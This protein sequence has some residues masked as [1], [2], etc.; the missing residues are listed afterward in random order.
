MTS[1][2]HL[3][4]LRVTLSQNTV[5]QERDMHGHGATGVDSFAFWKQM[6]RVIS[7]AQAAATLTMQTHETVSPSLSSSPQATA[8]LTL[9]PK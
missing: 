4:D 7:D 9:K 2:H 6:D 8:L 5:L 3:D 1:L